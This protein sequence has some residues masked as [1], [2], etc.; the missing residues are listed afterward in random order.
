MEKNDSEK[1]KRIS[2]KKSRLSCLIEE[3]EN[4][5]RSKMIKEYNEEDN[6]DNFLNFNLEMYTK[7]NEENNKENI[8]DNVVNIALGGKSNL[9]IVNRKKEEFNKYDND[10]NKEEEYGMLRQNYNFKVILLFLR[11]I[12]IYF[13]EKSSIFNCSFLIFNNLNKNFLF[14]TLIHSVNF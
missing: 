11:I 3:I 13:L 7:K 4:S 14:V 8:S 12:L 1:E 10:F 6:F 5:P 2:K 9:K